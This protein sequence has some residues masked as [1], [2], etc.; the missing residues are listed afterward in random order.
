[1]CL[2]MCLKFPEFEAGCAY[3]LFAYKIKNVYY[4]LPIV[5]ITRDST[6]DSVGRSVSRSVSRSVPL[7]SW[8]LKK[9]S[10]AKKRKRQRIFGIWEKEEE[11]AKKEER[12][13]KK[14]ICRMQV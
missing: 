14:S 7:Y 12:H 9:R 1:M 4:L 3:R 5:I 6:R 2:A 10:G 13:Q 8:E 11:L